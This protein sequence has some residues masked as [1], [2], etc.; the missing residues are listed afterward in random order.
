PEPYTLSLHDALPIL[1]IGAVLISPG[2]PVVRVAL[3]APRLTAT[4]RSSI[5]STFQ[6]M[7]AGLAAKPGRRTSARTIHG[8]AKPTAMSPR[9]ADRK[10]T[11]LNSSHRTI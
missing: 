6:R 8:A 5:P 3:K 2:D 10:S 7:N 1:A 11:R 9:P 4:T